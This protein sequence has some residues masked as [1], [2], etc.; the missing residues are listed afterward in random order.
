MSEIEILQSVPDWL[1]EGDDSLAHAESHRALLAS[2]HPLSAAA[3]PRKLT[4]TEKKKVRKLMQDYLLA[5]E[6]Y[7]SS[8]HYSQHRPM[9][10]LGLPATATWEADCSGYAT[11]TFYRAKQLLKLP[12]E[13]PNGLGFSGWG[14]TG[15]LL[16]HNFH[17]RI[18]LDRYF[19]VGDM[20][21]YG[22]ASS[23]RH[24]VIC[25][26]PGRIGQAVWSSFG[27]ERG[28]NAVMLTYRHDLLC[29]VRAWSLL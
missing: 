28:P 4:P 5:C 11:G 6:R 25:R 24:V 17:H 23:T 2:F 14:Y 10:H 12:I 22:P 15:T 3:R 18:P 8:K 13:D 29:V 9:T 26:K 21:L 7:E 16:S 19:Y 27:S 20:G 1:V